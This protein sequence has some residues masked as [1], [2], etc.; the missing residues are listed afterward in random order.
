MTNFIQGVS[1]YIKKIIATFALGMAL[2][3][4][5]LAAD[6]KIGTK[7]Q[8]HEQMAAVKDLTV[9]DL[10]PSEV[11]KLLEDKGPPPN[12]EGT[13]GIEMELV[14]KEEISAINVYQHGCFINRLGPTSTNTLLKLLG[15]SEA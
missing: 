14:T 15:R 11:K 2:T 7:E 10:L 4:P 3:T 13:E 1:P 12:A 6:C 5:M 9:S 8:A